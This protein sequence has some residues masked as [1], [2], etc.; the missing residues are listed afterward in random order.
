MVVKHH[1][2]QLYSYV[3]SRQVSLQLCNITTS[4]FKQQ[5]KLEYSDQLQTDT[6]YHMLY[7]VYFYAIWN[8]TLTRQHTFGYAGFI[9]YCQAPVIVC[10]FVY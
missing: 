5:R 4:Q 3:I 8:P 6:L 7:T 2:Q 10:C 1:E 9:W